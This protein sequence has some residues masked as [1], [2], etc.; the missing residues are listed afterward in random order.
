MIKAQTTVRQLDW[1]VGGAGTAAYA[2]AFG[3]RFY[4]IRGTE[5]NWY[6]EYP[7]DGALFVHEGLETQIAARRAAQAHYEALVRFE[8]VFQPSDDGGE[9]SGFSISLSD[10]ASV[11]DE[12]ARV[13]QSVNEW[14]DRTSPDDYP[15]HLLITSD[16]LS[17]ILRNFARTLEGSDNG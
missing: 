2:N 11:A 3:L 13:V 4:S 15:N 10:A 16:E 12:I 1:M 14:D 7:K 6:L 17:D 9:S 5:G 8:L